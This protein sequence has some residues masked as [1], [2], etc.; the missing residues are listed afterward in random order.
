MSKSPS[1]KLSIISF[2][3]AVLPI[4]LFAMPVVK[5]SAQTV[6]VGVMLP[7]HDVD[8]DGRRMVEYY[9]GMLMAFGDMRSEGINVN[10]HAWNLNIDADVSTF[11]AEASE[12]KCDIIF[13]PLYTKQVHALAEFCRARDIKMVIPF[14]I[15]GD[16]VANYSQIFQ[17]Y[18]TNTRLSNSAIESFIKLFSNAH[19]IF[20]DCNDKTSQKGAFTTALRTRLESN[21]I[22]YGVTNLNSS[23]DL[24]AKHFST[25]QNNIVILNSGRSPELTQA[26]NKLTQLKQEKP[27]LRI[28]LFGYTEWLMYLGIDEAKFHQFDAYI[29]STFFYNPMEARTQTLNQ[30]YKKWF[31]TGMQKSLPR[32][33]ITGYDHAQYFVRGIAKYG[34]AFKGLKQQNS[35][36]SLQA[37][38]EFKQVSNAGMQNTFFQLVHYRTD[39]ATE[40]VSF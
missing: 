21:N 23:D 31:G 30:Q 2:L 40:A 15:T 18:Q 3:V 1:R 11:M 4:I 5:V 20:I 27:G 36:R 7:L 39:G 10:V 9:R 8:G 37:P 12:A 38:L 13:G 25:S 35:Y 29:P 17:V 19:P 34:K 24:F 6:N 22:V 32:F 26:L 14:S 33:A 28:S 16:D